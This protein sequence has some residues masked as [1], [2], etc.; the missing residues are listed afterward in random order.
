ME[1]LRLPA[2]APSTAPQESSFFSTALHLFEHTSVDHFRSVATLRAAGVVVFFMQHFYF[3]RCAS[4]CNDA[5]AC[6]CGF[7]CSGFSSWS[8]F[9]QYGNRN[10]STAALPA[11]GTANGSPDANVFLHLWIGTC[12]AFGRLLTAIAQHPGRQL[13]SAWSWCSCLAAGADRGGPWRVFNGVVRGLW[14]GATH[15]LVATTRIVTID[16][17]AVGSPRSWTPTSRATSH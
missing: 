6:S 16:E 4:I 9:L 8:I 15:S 5:M 2:A 17:R 14:H 3:F 13:S 11:N 12:N 7:S 10:R 1:D